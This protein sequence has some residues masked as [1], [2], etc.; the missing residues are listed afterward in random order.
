MRLLWQ[1]K[2][3]NNFRQNVLKYQNLLV[4]VCAY[5]K[6]YN[7]KMITILNVEQ[8][9]HV[10]GFGA[11]DIMKKVIHMLRCQDEIINVPQ[12]RLERL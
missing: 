10:D 3:P 9:F 1:I 11:T 5:P 12:Y 7:N 4:Y 6:N 2:F 8:V